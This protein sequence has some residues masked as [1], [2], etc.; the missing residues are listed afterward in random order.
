M[1]ENIGDDSHGD[2]L[3]DG[4]HEG[5]GEDRDVGRDGFQR[6]VPGDLGDLLHHQVS[7]DD[8]GRSCREGRDRQK[9]RG[10]EEGQNEEEACSDSSQAGA[11]A[12]SDT[13]RGLDECR[14]GG[15]TQAGADSRADCVC[16][17]SA[18][19]VGK[20]AFLVQHIRLGSTSDQSSQ[21]VKEVDEQEGRD[22]GEEIQTQDAGEVQ[23]HESR[24]Q[25]C[26]RRENACGNQTVESRFGIGDIESAELADDAK[27]PCDNNTDQDIAGNFLDDQ[28]GADDHADQGKQNG[29]TFGVESAALNGVAEREDR[30]QRRAVDDD[31]S[32]LKTDEADE[33][34]DTDRYTQLQGSR[35]GIEDCLTD[36]CQGQ[37]DENETFSENC[38][39]G[40]F[41]GV[42]HT[43]DDR[44]GKI[45]VQAHT[46]RKGEGQICQQ[47]HQHAGD[48]GRQRRR[49]KDS[50]LIH[51]RIT[52]NARV[53][54]QDISHC[55]K[56]RD[57]GHDFGP[58]IRTSFLQFKKLFQN[59]I[60]LYVFDDAV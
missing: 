22:D 1:K 41:P 24:S 32:V 28:V 48:R 13:G 53:D 37:D 45:G 15:S 34:S 42:S 20:L 35:N 4:V 29:D 7:D 21:C 58:D 36:I 60:L 50:S 57:T 10:E 3:G 9:E 8:E 52:E 11:S 16:Q 40:D 59:I 6:I 30:D 17:Q 14:D 49:S 51:A 12:I 31:M 39:Q 19:D 56:G 44:I 2:S 33:K 46:G 26:R 18:A 43:H 27:H 55:H 54:G 38:R 47:C 23:L 5:H 25:G